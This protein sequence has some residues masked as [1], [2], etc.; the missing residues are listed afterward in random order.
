MRLSYEN[1]APICTFIFDWLLIREAQ[2]DLTSC[3]E[4]TMLYCKICF[5]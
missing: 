2:S 1:K 4:C 3:E 5:E